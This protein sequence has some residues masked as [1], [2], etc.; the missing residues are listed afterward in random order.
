M[1]ETALRQRLAAILAADVAGYSR[2]MSIDEHATVAA[3][4]ASR[5]VFKVAI[6]SHRGRV[7]DMAG[8]SVLA[9]F[10]TATGAVGAALEV[11]QQIEA[12]G[13]SLPEERR[14]RFRIGIHL[15][16]VIEKSDGSV[17]GDGV[18]IAARLEGL[19][20]PGGITVSDSVRGAVGRQVVAL[21][22][23]QGEQRVKNIA[24]PVRAFRVRAMSDP[25][26]LRLTGGASWLLA[27]V[28]VGKRWGVGGGLVLALVAVSS[29]ALLAR[30][31]QGG[32]ENPVP[33]SLSVAV[34]PFAV[35]DGS[36]NYALIAAAL[37]TELTTGLSRWRWAKVAAAGLTAGYQG[38]AIDA[39][40]VGRDLNVRYIVEGD[41]RPVGEKLGVTARL[42][43]TENATQVWSE[44]YEIPAAPTTAQQLHLKLRLANQLKTEITRAATD[45]A[46]ARPDRSTPID[47]VLRGD[48]V[49]SLT[50]ASQ[51]AARSF[52][53]KALQLD[54]QF[55]PALSGRAWLLKYELESDPTASKERLLVEMDALSVKAVTLDGRDAD[56][57]ALRADTLAGLGRWPEAFAANEKAMALLPDSPRQVTHRAILMLLTGRQPEAEALLLKA[58]EMDP[59]GSA[60]E[61]RHLCFARLLMGR[62]D[63]AL[64]DCERSAALD[65]WFEDQMLLASLYALKGD[66]VK[67][68]IARAELLKHQPGLT[69]ANSIWMRV[70]D[71]PAFR[72][73]LEE[74]AN[75]GLRK[76][77][78]P[79]R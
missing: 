21:F 60:G 74:H 63:E 6:E 29:W 33:H 51:R 15:G 78:I 77:G 37:G 3:L 45:R 39:R 47:E 24:E 42:I 35:A 17:Y 72:Q 54:P 53:D 69:V 55:V 48:A 76:A 30:P 1:D 58:I 73:Q 23:D 4:D 25:T 38:Q 66:A 28:R 71:V 56:V 19:A 12:H 31:W 79:E 10:E 75:A 43:E 13:A 27:M 46:V 11:Q 41:I 64:P 61:F 67:A 36:A 68:T 14:M 9:V 50:P 62:Y 16:D 34:M 7:I 49:A 57:W 22:E 5:A 32:S 2:L 26:T 18:N 20:E 52:Y 59:P 70:S 40:R 65:Q 8:D 44:R